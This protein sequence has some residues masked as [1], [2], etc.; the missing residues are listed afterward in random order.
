MAI[1]IAA[2]EFHYEQV[3]IQKNVS[4]SYILFSF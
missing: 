1:S 2:R 4:F 3:F